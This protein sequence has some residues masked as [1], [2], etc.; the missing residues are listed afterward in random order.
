MAGHVRFDYRW[1]PEGF[2]AARS[3]SGY[4]LYLVLG[5]FLVTTVPLGR[6]MGGAWPWL[7]PVVV[8]GLSSYAAL[9]DLA[10]F[11]TQRIE[12]RGSELRVRRWYGGV[13]APL[14]AIEPSWVEEALRLRSSDGRVDVILPGLTDEEAIAILEALARAAP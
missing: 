10:P 4:G 6:F 5:L 3:R 1:T 14:A 9:Q 2:D 11:G 7:L 13:S 8:L 12:I